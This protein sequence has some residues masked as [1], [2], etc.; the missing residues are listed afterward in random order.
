M[1]GI[2]GGNEMRPGCLPFDRAL[3]EA[4]GRPARVCVV[5]TAV[6]RN[7]SVPAA[8][9]LARRYFGDLGLEVVHVELHRRSD[10]ADA[11]VVRAL[12]GSRLTYLLGGDP[13]YLLDTLH[14]SSAWSA[15]V[16]AL[17]DGGALAGSSAGAMVLAET[18]LL[19][20]RNPSPRARHAKGALAILPGVVVVPHL[21]NFGDAWLES[22]RR[23]AAGRDI[24]G[25]DEAT[26]LIWSGSWAAH[27]PGVVKLWRRGAEPPLA[28]SHGETLWWR[29]PRVK[30][31]R[32]RAAT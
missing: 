29:A 15:A 13:G 10:A 17:L 19:R 14:G 1:V 6:V 12:R 21:N 11:G 18:L 8:L 27:G 7:G 3:L 31:T 23:E 28:R 20:S 16:E 30:A 4:A 26:G 32:A 25:L 24:V 2:L 5:P 9:A 22:A